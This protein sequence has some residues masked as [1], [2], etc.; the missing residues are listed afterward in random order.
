M[1]DL[2][3][4]TELLE[5]QPVVAKRKLKKRRPA[6]GS[7][8]SCVEEPGRRTK[9]RKH[10]IA[11]GTNLPAEDQHVKKLKM[12]RKLKRVPPT[13]ES[14]M[15]AGESRTAGVL[16][17]ACVVHAYESRGKTEVAELTEQPGSDVMENSVS[18][19]ERRALK[20]KAK[21]LK[22]EQ[23]LTNKFL[24]EREKKRDENEQLNVRKI[25][26][27]G[28]NF[29]QDVKKVFQKCG[30]FSDFSFPNDKQGRP[31]GIAFITFKTNGGFEEALKLDG[32]DY[33]GRQINVKIA[34]HRDGDH[35]GS[36][37]R[38]GKGKGVSHRKGKGKHSVNDNSNKGKGR[39]ASKGRVL[40]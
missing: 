19:L 40:A 20:R 7:S 2:D 3:D 4:W 1:V 24:D 15:P 23:E 9:K 37:K 31:M 34:A 11:N 17:G 14:V 39:L 5:E 36:G 28:F 22:R 27:G 6:A 13:A 18:D 25:F 38:K 35:K 8:V 16:T 33:A 21:K 30:E 32:S 10:E 26:V 12:K 29:E